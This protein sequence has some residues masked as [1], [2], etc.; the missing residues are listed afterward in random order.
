MRFLQQQAF[1]RSSLQHIRD[2]DG[3]LSGLFIRIVFSARHG[4][5]KSHF[6]ML[7]TKNGVIQ[8]YRRMTAGLGMRTGNTFRNFRTVQL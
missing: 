5:P 7:H 1:S 6:R 8:I 4:D 3:R 2:D